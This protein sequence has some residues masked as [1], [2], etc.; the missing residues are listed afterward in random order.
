MAEIQKYDPN[1]GLGPID[2]ILLAGAAS[3][4]SGNE[5]SAMTNGVLSPAACQQRVI[6]ILD[7]RS[8]LTV[9]Q[10]KML[11]VDQMHQLKDSLMERAVQ[12]KSVEAAKPLIAILTL[13]DKT[14]ATEKIDLA[15]AMAEINRAH[16][17]IM[18][19]GISVTLD[20]AFMELEKR[21]PQFEEAELLEVFNLSMP[22]AVHE[23]E[24]RVVE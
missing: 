2:R 17:Q 16:S 22:A 10:E 21:Y 3:K 19:A 8:W 18:L 14:L 12:F 13:L 23:I 9:A 24:A 20:R 7:S 15:K 4:R 11:L 6:E 1:A 5:L